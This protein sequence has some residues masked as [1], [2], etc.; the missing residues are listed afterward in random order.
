MEYLYV[1]RSCVVKMLFT[2][3]NGDVNLRVRCF[4]RS[5][6]TVIQSTVHI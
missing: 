6:R 1:D 3:M 2:S 4:N 5:V